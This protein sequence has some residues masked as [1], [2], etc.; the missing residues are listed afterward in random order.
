[1]FSACIIIYILT[2]TF[3]SDLISRLIWE[4]GGWPCHIQSLTD[5]NPVIFGPMP[6]LSYPIFPS[7]CLIL[8]YG[9]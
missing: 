1:M 2:L 5:S 4:S 7:R 6:W 8:R 3:R 9:I